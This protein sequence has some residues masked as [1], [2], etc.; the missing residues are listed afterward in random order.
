MRWLRWVQVLLVGLLVACSRLGL[1]P[2]PQGPQ[3]VGTSASAPALSGKVELSAFAAPRQTQASIGQE[4]AIRATVSLIEATTG[5]TV[6]TTLTEAN[7]TF[8]LTFANGFTPAKGTLYYLEAVKGLKTGTTL[9]N[10]VGADIVRIRTLAKFEDPFW[11]SISQ[12]NSFILNRTTTALTLLVSLRSQTPQNL[13]RRLDPELLLNA[14]SPETSGGLGPDPYDNPYG[15]DVLPEDLVIDAFE[16]VTEALAQDRDPF[17]LIQLDPADSRYNTLM[18]SVSGF[19]VGALNPD[20]QFIG[21]DIVIVGSGFSETPADNLVA[22]RNL[23]GTAVSAVVKSVSS[24]RSRLTVTVPEGAVTGPVT[25]TREGRTLVTPSFYLA[26][27]SGHEA[28]DALGNLYVANETFGTVVMIDPQGRIRPFAKNL[29]SP[30]SL[31]L[32]GGR[33]YVT[34]AGTKKGV[35]SLDQFNPAAGAVDFGVSGGIA[36][37]R[38]IAFDNEG[39]A[40]VTEG[41]TGKL[42]RIRGGNLAP[43][44][45]I[46]SGGV[47][48]SQPRAATFGEDGSLYVA[49][50]GSNNVLRL[51]PDAGGAVVV[52]TVHLQGLTAPW[53]LAF[54]NLGNLYVSNNKGNS[55]YR[56]SK[57]GKVTPFADMP[58]P[59]GL[60]T[61]RA[62]YVYSVDNTS[63]NV[64][65]ITPF[66]DSSVFASGFSSPTGIYKVGNDLY[67]LSETNNTLVKVDVTTGELSTVARGFNKPFGMTYDN[68]G[69]RDRF[70]VT[71]LG[72][73]TLARVDRPTG[74]TS[75]LLKG[76]GGMTGIWYAQGR[77]YGRSNRWVIS[78]DVTNWASPIQQHESIFIR[79]NGV[80]RDKSTSANR[81]AFIIVSSDRRIL[82]LAGDHATVGN[83]TAAN[84]VTVLCDSTRDPNL[85]DPRDVAVDGS[86]VIWTCNPSS[87][88]VTSYNPDGSPRATIVSGLSKPLGLV[89]DPTTNRIWVAEYDAKRVTPI[90]PATGTKGSSLSTGTDNPRNL[91][92]RDGTMALAMQQGLGRIPNFA[93]GGV[94]SRV[95]S[96]LG[97]YNDI[98]IDDDGGYVVLKGWGRKVDPTFS[99]DV[100]WY[101]NYHSPN[102]MWRGDGQFWITDRIRLTCRNCGYYRY[103]FI[104]VT[105]W[106]SGP[107]LAG[108][109]SNGNLYANATSLC[110]N[111]VTGR[112]KGSGAAR[113]EWHYTSG[114][115]ECWSP[116]VGAYAADAQG[117]FYILSHSGL[118]LVRVGADGAGQAFGGVSNAFRTWGMWAEPDGSALYQSVYSHHRVERYFP[119]TGTRE[120]LPFGLSAAE[121]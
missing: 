92:I 62:G 54:D 8:L 76:I 52:G 84:K 31:C 29:S 25:V 120:I 28:V 104:G 5:F 74:A 16:R 32:R 69:G 23:S 45:V 77:L 58:S 34:C 91:D 111:D 42:Y 19:T 78:Y 71:N 17:M 86:G 108:V 96:G 102:F 81:D 105:D 61:D 85:T 72:N 60:V 82:K 36:D 48:L 109:D 41:S 35:V 100:A 53:G 3:A 11:V 64:Y 118:R 38:G 88:T 90:D 7:G 44:A 79:N 121:M 75:A 68:E 15:E 4:I 18:S 47:T 56:R 67:V 119:A 50:L 21:K 46:V 66:G 110:S 12:N 63:N 106:Q 30:R 26:L 70:Y 107:Q 103:R 112:W 2:P 89:Y 73:S 49:N 97:G 80:A 24:D 33:L 13:D 87:G 113:E 55:I 65:R 98:G 43:E 94:Y 115:R 99:S 83:S 39:V 14:V 1:V 27:A 22:F 93:S 116:G 101:A 117:R 59:G 37:P 9:P 10:R 57:D 95:Y 51:T 114:A 6:A 40:W 20:T